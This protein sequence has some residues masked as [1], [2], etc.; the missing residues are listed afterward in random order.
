MFIR[1]SVAFALLFAIYPMSA[2]ASQE[3][4]F[5]SATTPPSALR[6]R[7]A[8]KQGKVAKPFP[9]DNL[10]GLLFKPANTTKPSPAVIL[11]ASCLGV[12]NFHKNW[13]KRL[14]AWGYTALIV[15]SLG[16]RGI[17]EAC[18][19]EV[20]RGF[21]D[22]QGKRVFDIYGAYDYL[23]ALNQVDADRIAVMGWGYS[24]V[25]GAV[26]EGGAQHMFA[27][28]FAGVV[29]FYPP[30][31]TAFTGRFVA[32]VLTLV[33]DK[34]DW[35]PVRACEKMITQ[36]ANGPSPIKLITYPNAA[37]GFDNTGLAK[38]VYRPKVWNPSKSPTLGATLEYNESA[39]S[40][41]IEDVK[42]Y[43]S[44]RFDS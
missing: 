40:N 33:G 18:G 20:Q 22:V 7:I 30:C 21:Q 2:H 9:P 42:K 27:G 23:A 4:S 37:H 44:E 6:I 32:P 16:S 28:K 17:K 19:G 43:L 1:L 14:R 29:A 8:K 24:G 10:K 26:L 13:A 25:F 11:M 15:D 3:V 38:S 41:A 31:W 12:E 5:T 39:T 34:D 36:G 35:T